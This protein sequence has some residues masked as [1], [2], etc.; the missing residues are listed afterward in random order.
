MKILQINSCAN[1]KS[2]GRIVQGIGTQIEI[3]NWSSIIAYGRESSYGGNELIKIGSNIS[4]LIHVLITR[5]FDLHGFGSWI[6]TIL[7][8]YKLKKLK[9]DIIHL[10]NV[11]GYYFN[12]YL[13]FNYI[14]RSNTPIVWTL[15]DCW[16]FTGHCTHYVSKNCNKWKSNCNKCPLK[17]EYPKS[18]LF[19][20]SSFNYKAKKKIFH[21]PDEIHF[22]IV[23]EWLGV[24]FMQSFLSDFP[25]QI[26]HNGINLNEFKKRDNNWL[27]KK[28]SLT[29]QKIILGVRSSW[30]KLHN[31][32]E[33][34]H[35]SEMLSSDYS[36]VLVGLT[37]DQIKELPEK[38]IGIEKTNSTL[39]LS[40]IY[41]DAF[42]FVN[43]TYLDSFPT[44]NLESL[45]C[46]TPVITYNTGG[47]P[48]S[49]DESVGCVVKQGDLEAVL[50]AIHSFSDKGKEYY[51]LNCRKKAETMF[52]EN[53]QFYEY[54]KLYKQIL[55][56]D[57]FV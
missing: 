4:N 47:S 13:F 27:S 25:F 48:E 26:I 7:F 49:I 10:H 3:I 5:I 14:K 36:I 39:E 51:S 12:I 35:L 11:H 17:K 28:Y 15:H 30:G 55:D 46:G 19:D 44:T 2:T 45:A 54:I 41:S 21:F 37:K 34:I 57:K 16:A 56:K 38:I 33:Y 52:D 23:S 40:E 50:K 9:P 29:S 6:S 22:T 8:I 32:N 24:Q 43:L 42:A 18:I 1:I 31:Y 20:S 53:R